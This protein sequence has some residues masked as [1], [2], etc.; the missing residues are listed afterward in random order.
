MTKLAP[1][2]IASLMMGVWFVSI[3]VGDYISGRLASVYETFPLPKLF[4][5]VGLSALVIGL[6]LVVFLKPI[7]RLMGGVS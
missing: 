2:R 5:M 1:R 4:G 3:S 7:K 6:M